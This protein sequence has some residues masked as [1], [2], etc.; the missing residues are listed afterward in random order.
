VCSNQE[1]QNLSFLFRHTRLEPDQ[2]FGG[3][4]EEEH[5]KELEKEDLDLDLEKND[6]KE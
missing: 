3:D 6:L 5:E 1:L 4:P 2:I